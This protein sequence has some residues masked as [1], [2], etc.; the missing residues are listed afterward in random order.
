MSRPKVPLEVRLENVS[1]SLRRRRAGRRAIRTR[2]PTP[3][4]A[5]QLI[6]LEDAT[7]LLRREENRL[8]MML[9]HNVERRRL[10]YLASK[11]RSSADA[12]RSS[13]RGTP[14]PT[15]NASTFE[16]L[17]AGHCGRGCSGDAAQAL[18]A[19]WL[20]VADLGPA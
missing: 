16:E 12:R 7:S 20:A 2:V 17:E 8:R 6:E 4:R 10:R 15:N 5:R 3:E 13:D 9:P 19:P 11:A 14:D 1:A 18:E